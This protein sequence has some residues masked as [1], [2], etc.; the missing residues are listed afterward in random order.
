MFFLVVR[1]FF[2]FSV[3]SSIDPLCF[4]VCRMCTFQRFVTHPIC[5]VFKCVLLMGFGSTCVRVDEGIQATRGH[6][7]H[8]LLGDFVFTTYWAM[9]VLE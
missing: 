1:V 6:R 3:D 4:F 5:V 8:H 2:F 9:P 7:R